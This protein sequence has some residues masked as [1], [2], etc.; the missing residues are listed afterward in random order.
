M[1]QTWCENDSLW[2]VF[3]LKSW[4]IMCACPTPHKGARTPGVPSLFSGFWFFVILFQLFNAPCQRKGLGTLS[5][6]VGKT[7]EPQVVWLDY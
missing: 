1:V 6:G 5:C 2:Y 4:H 7:Q 3:F